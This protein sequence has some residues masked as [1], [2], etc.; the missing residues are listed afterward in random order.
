MYRFHLEDSSKTQTHLAFG[1]ATGAPPISTNAA[2]SAPAGE[3]SSATEQADGE[4]AEDEAADVPESAGAEAEVAAVAAR[5]RKRRTKKEIEADKARVAAAKAAKAEARP[6]AKAAAKAAA[7]NKKARLAA[8]AAA[9][10]KEQGESS[11]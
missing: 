10:S 4:A 1:Q 7:S 2:N 11:I 3:I 5:T 6:S 8:Q 9:A